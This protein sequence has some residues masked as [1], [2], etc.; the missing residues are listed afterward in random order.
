MTLTKAGVRA[1]ID[2]IKGNLA[3]IET[4]AQ[5]GLTLHEEIAL[6]DLYY[7]S[8]IAHDLIVEG[9]PLRRVSLKLPAEDFG[10]KNQSDWEGQQLA[11]ELRFDNAMVI[12]QPKPDTFNGMPI[13]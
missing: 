12:G 4:K 3:N 8:G 10:A 13:S 2:A 7:A 1:I 9:T 6:E 5:D 11:S